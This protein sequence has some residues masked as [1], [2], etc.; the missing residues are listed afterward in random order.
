MNLH[1]FSVIIFITCD[2]SIRL[3]SEWERNVTEL[4]KDV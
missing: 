3:N 1:N 2:E 4:F